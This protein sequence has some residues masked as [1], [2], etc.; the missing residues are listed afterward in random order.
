[1]ENFVKNLVREYCPPVKVD[2]SDLEGAYRALRLYLEG[3]YSMRMHELRTASRRSGRHGDYTPP[4]LN[5]LLGASDAERQADNISARRAARAGCD[6]SRTAKRMKEYDRWACLKHALAILTGR[7]DGRWST[8]SEKIYR[9]YIEQ[10][11]ALR[12]AAAPEAWHRAVEE[13]AAADAV[14][15]AEQDSAGP[16]PLWG[17]SLDPEIRLARWHTRPLAE[18][19]TLACRAG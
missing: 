7:Y 1:M 3:E 8:S 5:F 12:R 14:W 4:G 19:I 18:R 10:A 13:R 15:I 17:S 6:V 16:P 11:Y 9:S 2:P